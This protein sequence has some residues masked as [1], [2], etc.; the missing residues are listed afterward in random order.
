VLLGLHVVCSMPLMFCSDFTGFGM[1]D[2]IFSLLTV[3]SGH[4][5][6]D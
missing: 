6:L 2:Q 3:L 5:L 1:D 4:S